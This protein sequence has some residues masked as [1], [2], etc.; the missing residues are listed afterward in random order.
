MVAAS[1][2]ANA[3]KVSLFVGQTGLPNLTQKIM[4]C[5]RLLLWFLLVPS[6]YIMDWDNFA[7]CR[8]TLNWSWVALSRAWAKLGE[9]DGGGG[10]VG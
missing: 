1:N 4:N 9:P 2:L 5:F 3:I 8:R 7:F 6:A 10:G